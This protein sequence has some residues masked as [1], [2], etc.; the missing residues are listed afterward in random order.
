M[1]YSLLTFF[2]LHYFFHN[3]YNVEYPGTI[4]VATAL[5]VLLIENTKF[6]NSCGC[7]SKKPQIDK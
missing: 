4:S 1:I 3:Y 7:S 6:K 2:G 5:V